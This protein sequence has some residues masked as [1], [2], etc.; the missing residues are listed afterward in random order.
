MGWFESILPLRDPSGLNA[1][2]F[3]DMKDALFI[4]QEDELF[5]EDWLDSYTTEILESNQQ[6]S[7]IMLVTWI[8]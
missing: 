3:N 2:T 7:I 8:I 6:T 5:G 1:E 4:Q